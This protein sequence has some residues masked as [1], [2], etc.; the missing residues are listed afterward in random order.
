MVDAAGLPRIADDLR[1]A[2]HF[3]H[4]AGWYFTPDFRMGPEGQALHDLLAEL[5]E[6]SLC[7]C[8]WWAKPPSSAPVAAWS[9]DRDELVRGSRVQCVTGPRA[10]DALITRS[11]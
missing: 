5:A 2:R 3:A 8:W 11:S 1:G 6:P 9:R 7:A 4:L 10:A